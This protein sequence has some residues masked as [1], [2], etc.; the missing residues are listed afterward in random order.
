MYILSKIQLHI[1]YILGDMIPPSYGSSLFQNSSL[2][3]T[4][5]ENRYSL[6]YLGPNW[7]PED[8]S[9]NFMDCKFYG[10]NIRL[11]RLTSDTWHAIQ[12]RCFEQSCNR[13]PWE[14]DHKSQMVKPIMMKLVVFDQEHS[15]LPKWEI[16]NIEE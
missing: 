2:N 12:L 10:M 11:R 14:K 1:H 5:G 6:G 4:P 7:I 9:K 3:K 8:V 15:M 16:S 13:S